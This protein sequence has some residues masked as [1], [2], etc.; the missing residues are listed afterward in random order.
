MREGYWIAPL[1]AAGSP[2]SGNSSLPITRLL[3]SKKNVISS[4]PSRGFYDGGVV[5]S[6]RNCLGE[7]EGFQSLSDVSSRP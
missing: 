4:P 3:K 2:Q 5:R 1:S 6:D 7:V